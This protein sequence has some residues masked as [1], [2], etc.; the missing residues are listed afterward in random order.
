MVMNMIIL[1]SDDADEEAL[2]ATNASMYTISAIICTIKCI[3]NAVNG[4]IELL[5]YRK[6]IWPKDEDENFTQA[7]EEAEEQGDEEM[8][9]KPMRRESG[10]SKL[11]QG[12]LQD[13]PQQHTNNN[14]NNHHNSCQ[15]PNGNVDVLDDSLVVPLP[16]DPKRNHTAATF[17][18]EGLDAPRDTGNVDTTF[19]DPEF[20]LS[21]LVPQFTVASTMIA[22]P[23]SKR[24]LHGE[25]D[26]GFGLE[27][28]YAEL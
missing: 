14:M 13:Q 21:P 23:P 2:T 3:A 1:S 10:K 18:W 9:T 17:G 22:S 16:V 8:Q 20:P 26:G 6:L 15:S 19:P 11:E 7:E 12:L 25:P 28:A 24:K 4:C 5:F 27:A